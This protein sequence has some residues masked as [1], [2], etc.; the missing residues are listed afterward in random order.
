[1]WDTLKVGRRHM[2]CPVVAS[3]RRQRHEQTACGAGA[4]CTPARNASCRRYMQGRFST[5]TCATN[6]NAP[7]SF[8]PQGKEVGLCGQLAEGALALQ[9][10]VH[11]VGERG[12]HVHRVLHLQGNVG[13]TGCHCCIGSTGATSGKE[14]GTCTGCVH[15]AKR[16]GF[17]RKSGALGLGQGQ[18]G[19]LQHAPASPST[20]SVGGRPKGGVSCTHC[21]N[22]QP[23]AGTLQLAAHRRRWRPSRGA[24]A[25][26]RQL[27]VAI[28]GLRPAWCVRLCLGGICGF[29]WHPRAPVRGTAMVRPSAYK[30]LSGT[31]RE[32]AW[33]ASRQ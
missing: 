6:A 33:E 12:G 31:A 7:P 8:D 21:G 13:F 2:Q 4:S 26:V 15:R 1:M 17:E 19:T 11:P 25:A 30:G 16:Q 24:H 3:K 10:G 5:A 32:R 22:T 29:G 27:P 18:E 23:V 20:H 9:A 14:A 28:T